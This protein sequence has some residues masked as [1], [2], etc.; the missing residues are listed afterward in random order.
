M[1]HTMR[2]PG[3][4]MANALQCMIAL[5]ELDPDTTMDPEALA[6]LSHAASAL[7]TGIPTERE[8]FDAARGTYARACTMPAL[9]GERERAWKDVARAARAMVKAKRAYDIHEGNI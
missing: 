7:F 3:D 6:T 2:A 9:P 5:E 1:T 8:A 4:R